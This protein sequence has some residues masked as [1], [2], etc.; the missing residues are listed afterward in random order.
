[1]VSTWNF[2]KARC[3]AAALALALLVGQPG[4]A[5][6]D[7]EDEDSALPRGWTSVTTDHFYFF[8]PA[9]IEDFVRPV[10][11]GADADLAR[12]ESMLGPARDDPIEVRIA[13]STKE[14][15]KVKPGAPPFEWAT[16]IAMRGE[17]MILLSM[18][19]PGGGKLVALHELFLHE[20]VHIVTFDATGRTDLPIWL[21]EGLAIT[22][23]G[24]FS[25]ARHK[26]LLA[27]ALQNDLLP[28]SRLDQH[29]PDKGR[30][31]NIAYAQS[32]DLVKF[33]ADR[34]GTEGA[35]IPKLFQK[36]RR[37]DAFEPALESIC[38]RSIKQIES[39]WLQS[40]NVQYKWVPSL[41]GGGAIWGLMTVLL[42]MAYV[43][44]MRRA[45]LV[46]KRMEIEEEFFNASQ[47]DFIIDEK[48]PGKS[49]K[50]TEDMKKVFHEGHFHT[51]H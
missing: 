25:F 35:V 12:M 48:E 45:R 24:E 41:T 13:R 23:S 30:K 17:R 5:F 27:A 38:K 11:D 43:R 14:L 31:V 47:K 49:P 18:T 28:I 40:L 26:T 34:Y 15:R 2:R 50:K 4:S 19:P 20:V 46:L 9:Q 37:G 36:L 39:D 42:I 1:V 44:R 8:Y 21:N 33:I 7:A 16:G 10:I 32:A 22:M 3:A 51:L 6:P 29:Y